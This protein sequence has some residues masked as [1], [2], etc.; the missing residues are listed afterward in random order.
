MEPI[1]L[2]VCDLAL[3]H[4]LEL[5]LNHQSV[6]LAK[7]WPAHG[8]HRIN[9]EGLEDEVV[10]LDGLPVELHLA[11][12]IDRHSDA[13]SVARVQSL[14]EA[15]VKVAHAVD[16]LIPVVLLRELYVFL[17]YVLKS[18]VA[19]WCGA[20]QIVGLYKVLIVLGHHGVVRSKVE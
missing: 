16:A 7:V 3:Q 5:S 13:L 15:R 14:R 9:D 11:E 1:A 20:Q 6:L 4:E 2:Q 12:C 18:L 19:L 10:G 17:N 8:H